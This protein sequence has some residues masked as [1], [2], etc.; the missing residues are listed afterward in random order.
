MVTNAQRINQNSS[1]N[2]LFLNFVFKGGTNFGFMNGGIIIRWI[3]PFSYQ[4]A[5]TSY[6]KG[7]FKLILSIVLTF[8][9][10]WPF[11]HVM[12]SS[13]GQKPEVRCSPS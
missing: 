8:G 5:V 12:F 7:L 2:N 13:H 1:V 9:L 11:R 4:P 6:G 3:R 10:M